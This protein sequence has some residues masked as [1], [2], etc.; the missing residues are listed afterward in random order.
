MARLGPGPRK[1]L[2]AGPDRST[3][4]AVPLA[5]LLWLLT[6][7]AWAATSLIQFAGPEYWDPVTV[8]DWT[9]VWL[10]TAAWLLFAPSV[11]LIGRFSASPRVA[12]FAGLCAVGAVIAGTANAL[13][14]GFGL[15][16]LGTWYVV[17][18]LMGGL[19]L[20]PLGLALWKAASTR[21]AGLSFAL[22]LGI[23]LFTD[24]GG[25]MVLAGLAALAGAPGWFARAEPPSSTATSRG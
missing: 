3:W 14:D 21:L 17:G 10:Y 1:H 22:F 11:V 2:T 9:A 18:F 8:L 12:A 24:G 16:G 23:M 13:E 19:A 5:R 7:V 15:E 20:V 25:L 4:L 6:G